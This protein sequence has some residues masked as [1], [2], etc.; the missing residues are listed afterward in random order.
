MKHCNSAVFDTLLPL[1][2]S[3]TV[4]ATV[5]DSGT[6]QVITDMMIRRACEEMD[7]SQ[8]W[9]M[10]D[11]TLAGGSLKTLSNDGTA[12]IISFRPRIS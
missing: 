3:V 4:C 11:R 12:Q 7:A 2:A 9:P 6:E 1:P 8:I 5:D 10:A